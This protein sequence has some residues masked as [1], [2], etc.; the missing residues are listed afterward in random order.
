MDSPAYCRTG[1][2][3]GLVI[4]IRVRCQIVTPQ[5]GL[6]RSFVRRKGVMRD[7]MRILTPRTHARR[8]R[9]LVCVTFSRGLRS[10]GQGQW[11]EGPQ[12]GPP[13]GIIHSSHFGFLRSETLT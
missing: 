13:W 11:T 8:L 3:V 2:P 5:V 9:S 4:L 10:R 12:S 7:R 1:S 6:S